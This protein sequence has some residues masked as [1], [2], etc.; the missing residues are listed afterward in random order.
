MKNNL[1]LVLLLCFVGL[2]VQAQSSNALALKERIKAIDVELLDLKK[3]SEGKMDAIKSEMENLQFE[4]A[5]L[6]AA[7]KKQTSSY[8]VELPGFAP[9]GNAKL[10]AE[11]YAKAKK[12]LYQTDVAEYER[13][14]NTKV[15]T[16]SIYEEKDGLLWL[17]KKDYEELPEERRIHID[18]YPDKYR[19][20]NCD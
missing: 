13:V 4:R 11:N 18:S 14:F 16:K 9:S 3:N 6:M 7:Y 5:E 2:S 10:D 1:F 15:N 12:A 20:K 19:V 8:N 17:S